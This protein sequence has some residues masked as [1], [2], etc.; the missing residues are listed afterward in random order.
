M[1]NFLGFEPCQ[2]PNYF[3]VSYNNEDTERVGLIAPRISH[4][5]VPL[6]YDYGIDYGEEWE[7]IISEK[8]SHSKAVL[9]F[10]TK[11]KPK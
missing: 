8:I 7:N 3:F 1:S 2:K 10:F 6:W 4:S 11:N 5:N 9:L